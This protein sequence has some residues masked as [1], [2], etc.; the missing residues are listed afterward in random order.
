MSRLVS[1]Q[2]LRVASSKSTSNLSLNSSNTAKRVLLLLSN[3]NQN[4]FKRFLATNSNNNNN[5][6]NQTPLSQSVSDEAD[7]PQWERS[8][9]YVINGKIQ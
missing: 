3:N 4:N 6:N 7:K 5:N 9:R 8:D 2:L 1:S